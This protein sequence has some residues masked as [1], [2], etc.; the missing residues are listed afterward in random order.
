MNTTT[1]S[2]AVDFEKIIT[3][4][5]KNACPVEQSPVLCGGSWTYAE[6]EA[7]LADDLVDKLPVHIW[8]YTDHT[9]I[10]TGPPSN[11]KLLERARLFGGEGDMDIRRE[12]DIFLWRFVGLKQNAPVAN[13]TLITELG[14]SVSPI[15]CTAKNALLWGT[16]E[17]G[18]DRWFD[19]RVS[20]AALTYPVAAMTG[21]VQVYYQ[22]YTQAGRVVAVWL[23]KLEVHNG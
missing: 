2:E 7:W 20:G 4:M 5:R 18:E 1:K 11:L 23:K 22:E 9:V 13:H 8:T 21:R 3:D 10:H 19:D 6:L 15:Y 14:T 17:K 12:G 16:R